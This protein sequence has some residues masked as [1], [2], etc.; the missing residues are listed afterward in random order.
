M[1][2]VFPNI[3][4]TNLDSSS[5]SSPPINQRSKG[6]SSRWTYDSYWLMMDDQAGLSSHIANRRNT[7][8]QRAQY[9]TIDSTRRWLAHLLRLRSTYPRDIVRTTAGTRSIAQARPARTAKGQARPGSEY[10]TNQQFAERQRD[11]STSRSRTSTVADVTVKRSR[12]SDQGRLHNAHADRTDPNP[13]TDRQRKIE[14]RPV[15]V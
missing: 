14:L 1:R 13:R 3:L 5:S 12:P 2:F 9:T 7:T 15:Q 11:Q 10:I 8:I 4:P 6:S